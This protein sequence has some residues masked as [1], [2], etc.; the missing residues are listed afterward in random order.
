MRPRRGQILEPGIGQ[1]SSRVSELM[2]ESLFAAS[3]CCWAMGMDTPQAAVVLQWLLGNTEGPV[4]LGF[5]CQD[6]AFSKGHWPL[7]L[8]WRI[9]CEEAFGPQLSARRVTKP[10]PAPS[11]PAW[12]P[13][14]DGRWCPSPPPQQQPA[15]A[16][17]RLLYPLPH[18]HCGLHAAPHPVHQVQRGEPG[19]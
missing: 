17:H 10:S 6:S 8:C 1:R 16:T 2:S 15:L 9:C 3:A 11:L 12:E 19:E 7:N 14:P 4:E 5:I 18:P 13:S